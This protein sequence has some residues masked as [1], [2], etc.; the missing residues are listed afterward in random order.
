[1]NGRKLIV[2]L[3]GVAISAWL[4]A[5]Y[6]EGTRAFLIFLGTGLGLL[7]RTMWPYM[8]KTSRLQIPPMFDSKY[9]VSLIWAFAPAVYIM[10]ITAI[11]TPPGLE[12]DL[13]LFVQAFMLAFGVNDF[14]NEAL[15][16]LEKSNRFK[17]VP[18]FVERLLIAHGVKPELAEKARDYVAEVLNNF[19]KA[20]SEPEPEE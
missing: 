7:A 17:Q 1:M 6:A 20:I 4:I 18:H 14:I 2:A 15:K 13:Y 12:Y 19:E 9:I 11:F 5:C 10:A 16:Q 8:R 3:A